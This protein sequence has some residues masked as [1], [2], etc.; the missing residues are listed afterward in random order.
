MTD[1]KWAE[2]EPN[3]DGVSGEDCAVIRPTD[4]AWNDVPC[5][6]QVRAVCKKPVPPMLHF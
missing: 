1:M 2:G 5:E 6:L 4:E 3:D